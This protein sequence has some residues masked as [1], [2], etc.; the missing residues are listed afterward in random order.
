MTFAASI[1]NIVMDQREIVDEFDGCGGGHYLRCITSH[2]LATKKAKG[3]AD[4]FA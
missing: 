4:E 3:G 2:C 1:F